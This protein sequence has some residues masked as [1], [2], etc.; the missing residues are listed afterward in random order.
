MP[1]N[2]MSNR[3]KSLPTNQP[4][5]QCQRHPFGTNQCSILTWSVQWAGPGRVPCLEKDGRG[6]T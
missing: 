6:K 3:R 1:Y 2:E 4:T 5:N